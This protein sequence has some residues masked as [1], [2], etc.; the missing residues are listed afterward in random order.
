MSAGQRHRGGVPPPPPSYCWKP[1]P[2]EK[3]TGVSC[4]TDPNQSGR[5]KT[6]QTEPT[7][8]QMEK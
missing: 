4:T 3:T 2:V 6:A 1:L 5:R 7:A 8:P